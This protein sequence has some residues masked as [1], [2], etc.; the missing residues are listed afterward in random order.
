MERERPAFFHSCLI[1]RPM[2]MLQLACKQKQ[3][4]IIGSLRLRKVPTQTLPNPTKEISI[5]SVASANQP[6]PA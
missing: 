5:I 1:Q 2:H 3:L 6:S 4:L